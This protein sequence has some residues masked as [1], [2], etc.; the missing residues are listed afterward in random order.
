M[1]KL[2][3]IRILNEAMIDSLKKNGKNYQAN[4]IIADILKDED[5]FS[6]ISK[7]DAFMIL[8]NL[9]INENQLETIYLELIRRK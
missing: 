5:C 7:E 6:K 3:E 9:D 8:R 4:M 1:T 2:E